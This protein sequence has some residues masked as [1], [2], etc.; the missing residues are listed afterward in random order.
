VGLV[1]DIARSR[2][3][4]VKRAG[5]VSLIAAYDAEAFLDECQLQ[6]VR[7]VGAEGVRIEGAA[8]V[9]DMGAIA[10]F[11][12]LVSEPAVKSVREAKRFV[13]QITSPDLLLDFTLERETWV[14]G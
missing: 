11:S 13:R 9:P 2:G 14:S 3:L 6:R 4:T 5:G 12:E 10:D 8:T 1:D 7:V